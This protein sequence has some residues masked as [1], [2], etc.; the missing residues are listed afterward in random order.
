MLSVCL[1]KGGGPSGTGASL[2]YSVTTCLLPPE[3]FLPMN[4]AAFGVESPRCGRP[5]AGCHRLFSVVRGGCSGDL[6]ML[7]LLLC[8]GCAYTPSTAST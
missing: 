6:Y 8:I 1:K 2:F 7:V 4:P 5:L 3:R